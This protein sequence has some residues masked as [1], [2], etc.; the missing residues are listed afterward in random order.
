MFIKEWENKNLVFQNWGKRGFLELEILVSKKELIYVIFQTG[1]QIRY[2]LIKG[3][4]T[5][6]NKGNKV[7]DSI[8]G[9]ENYI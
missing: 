5:M 6:L 1:F 3:L 9:F 8:F 7:E 4:W 2:I